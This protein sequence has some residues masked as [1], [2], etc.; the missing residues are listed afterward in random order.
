MCTLIDWVIQYEEF[1]DSYAVY[2]GEGA[3]GSEVTYL[4]PGLWTRYPRNVFIAE[5][6]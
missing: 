1:F 5:K 2:P 6:Q 3:Y 4:L